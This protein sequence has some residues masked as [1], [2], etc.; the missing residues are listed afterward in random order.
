MRGPVAVIDLMWSV[1]LWIALMTIPSHASKTA[2]SR[3]DLERSNP[4]VDG[5]SPCPE[6]VTQPYGWI[7]TAG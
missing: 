4:S 3:T 1:G 6:S 2:P 5:D 7:L